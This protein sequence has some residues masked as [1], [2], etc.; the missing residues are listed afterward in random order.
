MPHT[1]PCNADDPV[2]C[3]LQLHFQALTLFSYGAVI[4]GVEHLPIAPGM[5][6][7]AVILFK[8]VERELLALMRMT[9]RES[10]SRAVIKISKE[11][12]GYIGT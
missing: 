4:N 11:H 1:N 2:T 9:G 3:G 5:T 10:L 12:H 7:R 8:P 6:A